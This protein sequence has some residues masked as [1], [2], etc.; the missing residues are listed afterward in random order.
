MAFNSSFQV[1]LVFCVCRIWG[2]TIW[3]TQ[4]DQLL[5]SANDLGFEVCQSLEFG[6]FRPKHAPE[7]SATLCAPLPGVLFGQPIERLHS[8]P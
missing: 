1:E 8:F 7:N 4:G 2:R 3:W 5:Q 6:E